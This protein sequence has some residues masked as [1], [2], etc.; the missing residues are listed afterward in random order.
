MG[1]DPFDKDQHLHTKL[2]QY[3]VDIPDFPMKPSKWERF[4]NLLA[5]PAKDPLDS[6]ISTSN[7]ILLLKLAPIMGTAALALIQVLLFL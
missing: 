7:G 6:I 5:S 2:E 4:I 3:H 1:H